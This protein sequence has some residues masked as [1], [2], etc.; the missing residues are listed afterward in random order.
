MC[1]NPIQNR[2][3]DQLIRQE[4]MIS[5]LYE[6]FA[7]QFSQHASFWKELSLEEVR[8]AR[9]LKELKEVAN[10]EQVLFDEGKL[11]IITLDAF[12]VRLD[13]VLQKAKKGDF[14]LLAALNCAVDYETSL[15]EKNIFAHFDST[16]S[17]FKEVLQILQAE[18]QKH[19]EKVTNIQRSVVEINE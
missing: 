18:T 1:L 7:K 2:I 14:T 11:S 6:I 5:V 12:L 17:K 16:N 8:H 4:E 13:G 9:L 3:I 10:K 19:V 15:I